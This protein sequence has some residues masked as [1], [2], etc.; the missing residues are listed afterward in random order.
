ML[1]TVGKPGNEARQHTNN[2]QSSWQ[3]FSCE[4]P[5]YKVCSSLGLCTRKHTHGKFRNHEFHVNK[6]V[7]SFPGLGPPRLLTMAL[8]LKF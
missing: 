4:N 6:N 8:D 3:I 7:A 1:K 5:R 2:F